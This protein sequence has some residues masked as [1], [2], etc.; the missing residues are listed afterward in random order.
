[1]FHN[2]QVG[3]QGTCAVQH[4]GIPATRLPLI[5]AKMVQT[6]DPGR[7]DAF[8][9]L[10]SSPQPADLP[11]GGQVHRCDGDP[12]R[13]VTRLPA[14]IMGWLQHRYLEIDAEEPLDSRV[15]TYVRS[16]RLRPV[17]PGLQVLER[18]GT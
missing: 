10:L 14:I 8:A 2:A 7:L 5:E 13:R 3:S 1:V 12:D 15:H 9:R 4:T 11:R 17:N 16:R 18:T 6:F